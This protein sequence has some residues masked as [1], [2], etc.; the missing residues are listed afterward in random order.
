[1]DNLIFTDPL[2]PGLTYIPNNPPS[3]PFDTSKQQISLAIPKLL[4]GQQL[5]FRYV[6]QVATSKNNDVNGKL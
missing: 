1:M 5:A 3:L 4:S 6:L 2:E